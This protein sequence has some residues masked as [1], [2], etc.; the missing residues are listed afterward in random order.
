[1]LRSLEELGHVEGIA[2]AAAE[3]VRRHGMNQPVMGALPPAGARFQT[4]IWGEPL[5]APPIRP[6]AFSPFWAIMEREGG[7][8]ERERERERGGERERGRYGWMKQN[9]GQSST[10]SPM[11]QV[12]IEAHCAFCT[13]DNV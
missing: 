6:G 1:M 8:W 7:G 2:N 11:C 10:Q 3:A 12:Q 4:P 13:V 9:G 5:A